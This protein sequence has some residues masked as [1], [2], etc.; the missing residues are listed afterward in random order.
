[1][2]IFITG[3]SGFVGSRL[4]SY[5]TEKG[6]NV[7]VVLRETSRTDQLSPCMERIRV[8]RYGN[9][10]HA[11][12]DILKDCQPSV[13]IHTASLFLASHRPG[14]IRPLVQSNLLFPAELLEAM[15]VSG[16]RKF[17]NT[18]TSWQHHN[19]AAYCPVNLYA[20]TKQ[21][22][23][24]IC[25]YYMEANAFEIITLK[26]FDTYGT[27]DRRGKIVQ[28]LTEAEDVDNP[29]DASP[30]E[31]IID[32]VHIDDVCHAYHCALQL[33][34][35][36]TKPMMQ[37][38]GVASEKP[39]SLQELAA[40]YTKITGKKLFVRWGGRP[41]RE[42]EVMMPWSSWAKLP[43]WEAVISLEEGLR[44]LVQEKGADSD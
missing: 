30:G 11:L 17:I 15:A 27:G 37:D 14:H 21:A 9:D 28:L 40:L 26:L 18:G 2:N 42:R 41:Y 33:L 8:Y 10:I 24:D 13:V 23:E 31:Q 29:L 36:N 34:M 38:F 44:L 20:A 32:L 7:A 3:A 6:H 1:M 25:Q 16:V 43:G 19:N 12:I 39:V 22:F 35:N 5:F 4:T